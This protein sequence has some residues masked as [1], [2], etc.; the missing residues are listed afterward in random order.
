MKKILCRFLAMSICFMFVFQG[1][2]YAA[3]VP[4]ETTAI[5]MEI[6]RKATYDGITIYHRQSIL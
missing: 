3:D 1:M 2:V 6:F 4:E 5:I